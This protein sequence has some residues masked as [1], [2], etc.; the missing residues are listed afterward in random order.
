M[1]DRVHRKDVRILVTA[2]AQFAASFETRLRQIEPV[3]TLSQLVAL[4]RIAQNPKL[5]P[6]QLATQMRISRQLAW[7]TCKR[8][9]A[10]GLLRM[11]N[12]GAGKR[13][14][15]IEATD[16]GAAH[17][18]Q[19]TG[20]YA[21]IAGALQARDDQVDL[22]AVRKALQRLTAA[23]GQLSAPDEAEPDSGVD[24]VKPRRTRKDNMRKGQV[25][26]ESQATGAAAPRV[27]SAGTSKAD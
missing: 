20:L 25:A 8:L 7:Q 12:M 22:A 4:D 1:P 10:L 2:V 14:I 19:V 17:L 6:F 16:A 3:L 5:R 15:E 11:S 27:Q 21:A 13:G 23:A 26:I 24:A 18:R 9:E